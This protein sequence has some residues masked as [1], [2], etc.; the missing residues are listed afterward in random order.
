MEVVGVAEADRIS[1]L[2]HRHLGRAKEIHGRVYAHTIDIINGR[3]AYRLFEHLGKVVGRD[4]DHRGELLNV[5]L[6]SEVL[7]NVADDGTKS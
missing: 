2:G 1:N 4:V 5:Y 3:L 6:L 7:V